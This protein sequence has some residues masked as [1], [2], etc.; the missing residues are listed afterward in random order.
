MAAKRSGALWRQQFVNAHQHGG[1]AEVRTGRVPHCI[2][3]L[4]K[5]RYEL[6][7]MFCIEFEPFRGFCTHCCDD[8][9]GEHQS[10]MVFRD[11]RSACELKSCIGVSLAAL[12]F[13]AL[14][15]KML[16]TRPNTFAQRDCLGAGAQ[17][18]SGIGLSD[19]RHIKG[20]FDVLRRNNRTDPFPGLSRNAFL[21]Q[22]RVACVDECVGGT[23]IFRLQK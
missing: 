3:G 7:R 13:R 11:D 18:E 14:A 5:V 8:K 12:Q 17:K 2:N 1:D 22:K 23:Q 10:E 4:Y 6:C 21:I 9:K 16:R 15:K 20:D 19:L